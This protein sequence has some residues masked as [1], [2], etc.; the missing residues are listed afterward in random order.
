MTLFS[1]LN[2]QLESVIC[3]PNFIKKITFQNN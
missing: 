3:Q 1:T 2:Q